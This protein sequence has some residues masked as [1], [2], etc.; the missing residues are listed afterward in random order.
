VATRPDQQMAG[1]QTISHQ[2]PLT[3]FV[4]QHDVD[5]LLRELAVAGNAV[6]IDAAAGFR[7]NGQVA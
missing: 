5:G 4:S 7:W 3:V 2:I 6:E 1:E